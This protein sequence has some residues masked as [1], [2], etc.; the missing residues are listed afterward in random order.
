MVRICRGE[1]LRFAWLEKVLP[2][3]DLDGL[4][5]LAT[6]YSRLPARLGIP[7]AELRNRALYCILLV[8]IQIVSIAP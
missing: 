8:L 4:A 1:L 7:G 5:K 2:A 6:S 3:A